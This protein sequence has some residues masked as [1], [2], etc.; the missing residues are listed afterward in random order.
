VRENIRRLGHD[1]CWEM[2]DRHRLGRL[3]VVEA[4]RATVLPVN[5]AKDGSVLVV[6]TRHGST[7]AS[8]ADG[9]PAVLEVDEIDEDLERGTSVIVHGRLRQIVREDE[10][11]RVSRLGL[12]PWA[13]GEREVFVRLDVDDIT[14]RTVPMSAMAFDGVSADGG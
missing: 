6:R 10:H 2:V 14:G 1:E 11:E 4:G 12:H 3:A 5:F 7:V 8:V 9:R 13:G